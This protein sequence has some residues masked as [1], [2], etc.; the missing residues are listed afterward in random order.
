LQENR[1]FHQFLAGR[2]A[3]VVPNII[4]Q[5]IR[6]GDSM[7]RERSNG[8]MEEL[9]YQ[10]APTGQKPAKVDPY[11]RE[12]RKPVL[13]DGGLAD[14]VARSVDI[15]DTGTDKVHPVDRMLI[16]WRDSGKWAKAADPNDRK[17]WFPSPILK[18]EFKHRR[19]GQNV[20]MDAAQLKEFREMAGKRTLALLKLNRINY[21]SPTER[22]VEAVKNAV[23]KARTDAKTILS[24]KYSR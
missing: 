3:M 12:A 7:F 23:S 1:K 15:A 5:P 21:D 14:S 9:L 6:E 2:I 16:K 22:D 13:M 8:F 4:K 18:A 20:E 10:V 24:I 17:P 19:T 11:G